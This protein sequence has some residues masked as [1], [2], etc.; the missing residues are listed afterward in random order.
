M[1]LLSYLK[2]NLYKHISRWKHNI[3]SA[4]LMAMQSH[5]P[6]CLL[7][8]KRSNVFLSTAPKCKT[9][10]QFCVCTFT[11]VDFRLRTT[12]YISLSKDWIFPFCLVLFNLYVKFLNE[13][14]AIFV[15]ILH[16]LKNCIDIR[17]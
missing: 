11:S 3:I 8:I 12:S 17:I 16:Y 1:P 15:W 10:F 7:I 9:P 2:T 13:Q 4:L 5:F 14:H 6:R